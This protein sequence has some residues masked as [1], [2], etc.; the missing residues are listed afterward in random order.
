MTI[1]LICTIQ[2]QSHLIL[3]K[4]IIWVELVSCG[5][6]T[7]TRLW[8]IGIIGR[9]YE[10]HN[11]PLPPLP[12]STPVLLPFIFCPHIGDINPTER[13]DFLTQHK[14]EEH[15][16]YVFVSHESSLLDFPKSWPYCGYGK[17]S[18]PKWWV[19]TALCTIVHY[20]Y[21]LSFRNQKVV[22]QALDLSHPNI[23][24]TSDLG[25]LDALIFHHFLFPFNSLWLDKP[26]PWYQL[27]LLMYIPDSTPELPWPPP[28]KTS[29]YY[30]PLPPWTSHI[31]FQTI[32][33]SLPVLVFPYLLSVL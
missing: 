5:Y 23:A 12:T 25:Q 9:V 22:R 7:S 17:M 29:R 8:L 14:I 28:E 16:P 3:R 19:E 33:T 13:S 4:R 20:S 24:P 11:F 15:L 6:A 30:W 27:P 26:I 21:V 10:P 31:L 32:N 1:I 2:V 18:F